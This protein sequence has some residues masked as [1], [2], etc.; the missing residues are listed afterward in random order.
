LVEE[1]V[2]LDQFVECLAKSGLVHQSEVELL[3]EQIA[4]P[5]TLSFARELIARKRLTPMQA[6]ALVHG[7]WRGL[8]LGNYVVLEKLGQGGMG[9]VFKARHRMT[10]GIVCLKVLQAA[11]RSS[12]QHVERFR[13]EAKMIAA[14]DHPN[15]VVAHDADESD[16]VPYLV[17]EFVEGR[18][19]AK[20][21]R[22]HGTLSVKTAVRYVLQAAKALAYAHGRGVIH[23][24]VKPHNLMLDSS[25]TVK[26]LDMGLA[27][28]DLAAPDSSSY[29]TMTQSG[30]VMGTV[31][32]I[33]PEQAL[34]ARDADYRS[35]V[36]SLGCTLHFLLL[37]EVPYKGETVM[38]RL[39]AH[40]EHPIPQLASLRPDISSELDAIFR[41]MLAKA[42]TDRYQSMTE[43]V[44]DLESLLRGAKPAASIH[45]PTGPHNVPVIHQLEAVPDREP[46]PSVDLDT[47]PDLFDQTIPS[48]PASTVRTLDDLQGKPAWKIPKKLLIQ[49]GALVVL[50]AVFIGLSA[51]TIPS[52]FGSPPALIVVAHEGFS[53]HDY[54]GVKAALE[55]RG[56]KYKTASTKSTPATSNKSKQVAVDV[57]LDK[58]DARDFDAV[59]ICG[60]N[61]GDLK[62]SVPFFQESLKQGRVVAAVSDGFY[63]MDKVWHKTDKRWDDKQPGFEVKQTGGGHL[64]KVCD[65]NG[66]DA[67]LEHVFAKLAVK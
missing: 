64:V 63:A 11:G 61:C 21:V 2:A 56:I 59:I 55:Q 3:V 7:K 54:D 57:T 18:D 33:A 10:G 52:L 17:M 38:E 66:A 13:R 20:Y 37:G 22:Q 26:V 28:F 42:P 39:V 35:D 45:P 50:V 31:D 53:Q 60:G 43:L 47:L 27:R 9:Q 51:V 29:T 5:D 23:R 48:L 41:R 46:P 6:R 1:P 58:A 12:P 62:P 24:D 65:C 67:A 40:R 36:Y 14:L 30:T 25:D 8:I 32:Y 16:G 34:N 44:R 19:L 49:V 4:P 15:I